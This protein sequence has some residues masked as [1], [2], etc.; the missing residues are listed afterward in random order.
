MSDGNEAT[1][2]YQAHLKH[3]Y[4]FPDEWFYYERI[5]EHSGSGGV[6]A[7]DPPQLD[8]VP[9]YLLK[10][11]GLFKRLILSV[12]DLSHAGS[13]IAFIEEEVDHEGRY[14]LATLRKFICYETTLIVSYCRPFSESKGGIPSLS[15]GALGIKLSPFT[16][17]LH[18]DLIIKRNTL[19]AH[20]DASQVEYGAPVVMKSRN[21]AGE[22]FT[23]LNPPR[24][25]EGVML[26]YQRVQQAKV[27]N[28]S[29]LDAVRARL[30]AM[31]VHFL[32]VLPS[33]DM[34]LHDPAR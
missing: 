16:R 5:D 26:D 2:A 33:M 15:Y 4:G 34:D 7:F 18:D 11:W 29:L 27:L 3:Q 22:S 19:F 1:E 24:F 13:A 23:C 20:S 21:W 14:P 28:T 17:A 8:R 32:D 12:R 10:N 9:E 25:N 31:H 6:R 30:Q